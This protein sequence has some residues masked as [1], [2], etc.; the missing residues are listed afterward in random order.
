MLVFWI[1]T[2]PALHVESIVLCDGEHHF[3]A[4]WGLRHLSYP[5]RSRMIWCTDAWGKRTL[6]IACAIA[7]HAHE[8]SPN[9]LLKGRIENIN[10]LLAEVWLFDKIR[11][12]VAE[13]VRMQQTSH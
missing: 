11:D 10:W 13:F 6:R 2:D 3:F 12:F 7:S 4:S 9:S 5:H 8:I 1:F